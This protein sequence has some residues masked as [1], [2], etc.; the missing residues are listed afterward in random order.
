VES[1]SSRPGI[2]ARLCGW[3][4]PADGLSR[5][6]RRKGRLIVAFSF[7][8]T[9]WA[10][11]FALI[12]QLLLN[13]TFAAVSLLIAGTLGLLTTV[14]L[15]VS[16][17]IPFAGNYLTAILFAVVVVCAG[18]IGERSA[19]PLIW[20]SATPI[21]GVCLSGRRSGYTW[22]AL[23]GVVVVVFLLLKQHHL[24]HASPFSED[25]EAVLLAVGTA[26]ITIV[27]TSYAIVF[28]AIKDATMAEVDREKNR[29]VVLHRKLTDA[30]RLAGM[31]EVAAGILHSVGNTLNSVNVSVQLLQCEAQ[32][33]APDKVVRAADLLADYDKLAA[34]PEKLAWLVSYLKTFGEHVAA[35]QARIASE[36]ESINTN[37]QVIRSVIQMEE[38]LSRAASVVESTDINAEIDHTL[39]LH[40]AVVRERSVI[41][42]RNYQALPMVLTDRHR[43]VYVVACLLDNAL[44]ALRAAPQPRT[45]TL[46]TRQVGSQVEIDI[47]DNGEGF[48][49]EGR[50]RLFS[51]GFSMWE[52]HRG[53]GL[54]GS[55]NAAIEMKGSLRGTS[56]GPGR[57]ATFTLAI[58]ALRI[59]VAVVATERPIVPARALVA[60]QLG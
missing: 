49:P 54:H 23:C 13:N 1:A 17:S 10:P 11:I 44:Y 2:L 30:S 48:A 57:G 21:M 56:P 24:L 53:F 26:G 19:A 22:T 29:I 40:E 39:A 28:E 31:A 27:V 55:A 50:D 8:L 34:S 36:A 42:N 6:D 32:R 37:V 43:L 15:R 7:A 25:A 38:E 3:A 16:R 18:T 60:E 9:P 20:L 14:A 46:R 41:V 58:P 5:D 59:G 51:F 45:L 4:L 47:E 12:Y 52:G 35:H 33:L